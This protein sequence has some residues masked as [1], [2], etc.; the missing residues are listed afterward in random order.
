MRVPGVKKKAL[1]DAPFSH[2]HLAPTVLDSIGIEPPQEFEGRSYWAG[3]QRGGDWEWA[4]SESIGRCTNPMDAEKRMG[5]RVLAVQDRR[6]KLVV[7]F[8]RK[9]EE[10]FDLESDPRELRSLPLG[11]EKSTRAR[12][13]RRALQHLER[14]ARGLDREL[15]IRARVHEIGLEWRDSEMHSKTL[16]S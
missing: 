1:S 13:L 10:L 2:V 8:D 5:G 4:V 12:L 9:Q 6:H 11:A 7:D 15:A 14:P 16:V 3:S